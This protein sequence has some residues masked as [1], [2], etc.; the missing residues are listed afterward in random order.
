MTVTAEDIKERAR[1]GISYFQGARGESGDPALGSEHSDLTREDFP[2]WVTRIEE[3]ARYETNANWND[4]YFY[5]L[6]AETL[7]DTVEYGEH[8]WEEE[9]ITPED[10]IDEISSDISESAFN[11]ELAEWARQSP[12]WTDYADELQNKRAD[13][14]ER[15]LELIQEAMGDDIY[16]IRQA[17][18]SEI[19]DH[20]L[21]REEEVS[22]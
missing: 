10:M 16:H 5:G 11:E 22:E 15:E 20:L 7:K 3:A 8:R 19:Y 17:V 12:K 6:V 21:E 14:T 4:K 1:E 2:N 18:L 9:S 13:D